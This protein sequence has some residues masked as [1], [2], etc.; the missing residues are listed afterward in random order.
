MFLLGLCKP[1]RLLLKVGSSPS[2]SEHAYTVIVCGIAPV[3]EL[4]WLCGAVIEQ[5]Y[6]VNEGMADYCIILDP[7]TL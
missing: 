4:G 3:M 1:C 5:H 6:T 7:F 2:I